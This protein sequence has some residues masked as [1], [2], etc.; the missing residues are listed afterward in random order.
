MPGAATAAIA[1][2]RGLT[3]PLTEAERSGHFQSAK[4]FK[5]FMGPATQRGGPERDWHHVVEKIHADG[6]DQFPAERLHS[7][8]NMVAVP[9]G[10]HQLRDGLTS[11]FSKKDPEGGDDYGNGFFP[12]VRVLFLVWC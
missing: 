9:R 7:V 4:D 11:V 8:E 10:A 1:A 2:S 6:T 3:R 12:R 5:D